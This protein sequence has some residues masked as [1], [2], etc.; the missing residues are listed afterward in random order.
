M[1]TPRLRLLKLRLEDA[2]LLAALYGDPQVLATIPR[3]QPVT[4]EQQRGVI[5]RHLANAW[6]KEGSGLFAVFERESGDFVGCCGHLFWDI[7]G[8][9]E[10]E[11]GYAIVPR[12]WRKGYAT[13]A[14]R[15]LKSDAFERLGKRRVI[16]LIS[17]T[18]AGSMRVA[19]NN[20]MRLEKPTRF[21]PQYELN[22]WSV[23]R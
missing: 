4:V 16:S 22:V 8:V 12:H 5:E 7:D 18:N 1:L 14:A 20:G 6:D 15:F 10:T 11:V 2:P 3:D 9:H 13:E 19:Q 21:R 17:P 23:E